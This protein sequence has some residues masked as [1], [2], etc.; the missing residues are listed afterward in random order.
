M[1]ITTDFGSFCNFS[2][3]SQREHKI[4]VDDHLATYMKLPDATGDLLLCF[5]F[6]R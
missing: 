3:V 4:C 6:H 2:R 1:Q 5:S